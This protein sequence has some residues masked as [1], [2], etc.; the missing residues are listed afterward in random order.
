MA[1]L[2]DPAIRAR[3]VL[4]LD[5][6]GL[7]DARRVAKQL[8]P[9]C[10]WMKVGMELAAEAGP[11]A[12]LALMD[13]GSL[14][15]AD[16]K[17]HDIPNTVQRASRA[18]G[19][20]GVAMMNVHAAGGVEMVRAGLEGFREGRADVGLDEGVFIAVTVLTS[21]A[22]AAAVPERMDIA[23]EAGCDGVVCAAAEAPLARER[24]LRP[25]VP[26]VRLPGGDTHDQKRPTTPADAIRAGAEWLVLAR[27]L[28]AA[29]DPEAAAAE[30]HRLMADAL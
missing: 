30:A 5:V 22:N 23:A 4:G 14:V 7:D 11:S 9:W 13:E 26:G 29:S 19:R 3:C 20:H 27:A 24:G 18:I 6:G 25:L 17:F 12:Y 15:F 2:I 10:A 21:E 8:G 28:T 1:E 16:T